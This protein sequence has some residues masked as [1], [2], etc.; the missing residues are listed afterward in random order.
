M[1]VINFFRYQT[2]ALTIV[3]TERTL[4]PNAKPI[5]PVKKM[6]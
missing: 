4:K 1:A 6:A 3:K 2:G 5:S